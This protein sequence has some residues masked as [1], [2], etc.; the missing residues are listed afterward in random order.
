MIK[1]LFSNALLSIVMDKKAR[2]KLKVIREK[3]RV[4]GISSPPPL[5]SNAVRSSP[6][7]KQKPIEP[8]LNRDQ[9]RALIA[10]TLAAAQKELETTPE[11]SKTLDAAQH[12][13][14]N[15][16][17]ISNERQALIQN[18]LNIQ[19]KQSKVLDKLDQEQREKLKQLAFMAFNNGKS[20]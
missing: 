12:K 3:K 9:T 10:E 20:S 1:N 6:K 17:A 19:K 18:A 5:S 14:E 4:T 8:E 7:Q 2:N 13:L 11:L 15:R 16:P